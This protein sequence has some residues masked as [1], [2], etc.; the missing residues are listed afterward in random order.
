MTRSLLIF[1]AMVFPLAQ[2][3]AAEIDA[4]TI[5]TLV[6]Q[7]MRAWRVPGAAVAIVRDGK[8]IYLKGHGAREIGKKGD[9]G[10]DTVF[11]IASCS[12]AF[13]TAA[14]ATLVDEK[15]LQWDDKV[16]KH[17]PYFRLADSLADKEVRLRDLLCHRTGLANHNILWYRS[18]W[19][20]EEQIRRAGK[21]PLDKSFR[22]V[23]QYQSTMFAAAG[24][25]G[26]R[27]AGA[28][29][30]DLVGKRLL[31]PL[32]MK[33]TF[34]TSTDAIKAGDVA[35]PHQFDSAGKAVVMDRYPMTFADPAGSMH[36][37]ARDLSLWLQFHL[38]E[39]ALEGKRLVSAKSLHETHKPQMVIRL[40]VQEK[41]L[42]P[43]TVQLSYGLGWVVHDRKGHLLIS[44]GGAIDGFR[45]YLTMAPRSKIG[46]AILANLS[47]TSMQLALANR[48]LDKM[49]DIPPRDWDALHQTARRKAAAA[50]I[51]KE[52]ARVAGRDLKV[53]PSKPLAAYVGDYTNEVYG[54]VKIRLERETLTWQ[55]ND[56]R[57]DLA[58]YKGDSFYCPE[59]PIIPAEVF[60][61]V[62]R[63]GNPSALK[64]SGAWNNTFRREPAK[65]PK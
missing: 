18:P 42:H 11:P 8:V 61:T 23:F 62:P 29:Y 52:K 53:K 63:E 44:H 14:L 17:L 26:A 33:R 56:F 6:R 49:L 45:A 51:E 60:F 58:L 22:S 35:S 37:S 20:Q 25:A 15:K 13:A 39:G 64:V 3:Q 43:D 28:S 30:S 19:S 9:V 50:A 31:V 55:W 10:A 16:R 47:D 40:P 21:L 41:P 5:D 1:L 7:S 24:L 54:T 57:G 4:S 38:A 32:G 12:K 48:I 46:I 65:S 2:T 36:S 27:T 59:A 34:F